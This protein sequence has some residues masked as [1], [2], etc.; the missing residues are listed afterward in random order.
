MATD[1][2]SQ[3]SEIRGRLYMIGVKEP[4]EFKAKDGVMYVKLRPMNGSPM[5]FSLDEL[6]VEGNLSFLSKGGWR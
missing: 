5:W 1:T 2:K 6:K 3:E 4:S